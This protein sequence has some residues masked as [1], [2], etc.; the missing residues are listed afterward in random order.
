MKTR[1]QKIE[2]ANRLL[3]GETIRT[4]PAIWILI[5]GEPLPEGYP[6]QVLPQDTVIRL[7]PAE[8]LL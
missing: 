6:D 4:E 1:K 2:E 5:E 8:G 3:K 7:S